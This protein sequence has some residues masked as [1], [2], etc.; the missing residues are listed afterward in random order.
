MTLGANLYFYIL[1]GRPNFELVATSTSGCGHTI[2]G[3]YFVFH[4][5]FSPHLPQGRYKQPIK[6]CKENYI[7]KND[8]TQEN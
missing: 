2:L 7:N 1:L 6:N 3:M 4:L 8:K 5:L